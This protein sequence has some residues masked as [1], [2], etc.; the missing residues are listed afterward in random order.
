MRESKLREEVLL[1]GH[2]PLLPTQ[3]QEIEA[4]NDREELLLR[5]KGLARRIRD[6]VWIALGREGLQVSHDR[7]G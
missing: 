6:R 4:V 2:H 3:E 7:T 1:F 5:A